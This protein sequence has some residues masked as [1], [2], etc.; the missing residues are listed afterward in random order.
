M[1]VGNVLII[2][3]LT[4]REQEYNVV[5]KYKWTN[6]HFAVIKTPPVFKLSEHKKHFLVRIP[7]LVCVCVMRNIVEDNFSKYNKYL[8]KLI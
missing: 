4:V 6:I 5:F 1:G 2:W 3:N 7:V 8:P